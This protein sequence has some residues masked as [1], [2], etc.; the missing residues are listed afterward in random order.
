VGWGAP[1]VDANDMGWGAPG[2]VA[3]DVDG[4]R[5]G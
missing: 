5:L 2:V 4:V 1:G 3:N